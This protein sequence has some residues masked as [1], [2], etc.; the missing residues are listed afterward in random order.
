MKI[1]RSV[2]DAE[3]ELRSD[4]EGGEK[5]SLRG[6]AAK[7]DS[8]SVPLF[9][10]REKIKRGAFKESLKDNNVRALW[11]HNTDI[12]LG[13]TK[14][15]T[16]RLEED[17]KG[18]RFDLDLPETQAGRDAAITVSRG[19]VEGMSFAFGVQKEE[20]DESDPKDVIR[21]LIKL[22]LHEVSPTAF[23]AYTKTSV[24]ARSVKDDYEDYTEKR[25]KEEENKQAIINNLKLKQQHLTILSKEML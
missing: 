12:V 20:W 3:I 5:K 8:L 10:F 16:L 23:P 24:V 18:L 21:T 13:S 7:F 25:N 2:F 15:G 22:D 11:N 19:D 1:T 17:D 14:N 4:G 6:Y 9:G